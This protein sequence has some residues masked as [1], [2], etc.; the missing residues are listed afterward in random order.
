[1]AQ[2]LNLITSP[3]H[4]EPKNH[5]IS[6]SLL[7]FSTIGRKNRVALKFIRLIVP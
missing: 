7:F 6:K 3:S 4:E 1:M 2:F 5:A